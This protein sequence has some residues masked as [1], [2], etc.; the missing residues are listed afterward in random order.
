MKKGILRRK[1]QN[2]CQF[3]GLGF[4]GLLGQDYCSKE[5][6]KIARE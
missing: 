5:C 2:R 4:N 6:S 3:C 1:F